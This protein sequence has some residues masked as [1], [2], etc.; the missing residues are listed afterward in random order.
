MA[1]VRHFSVGTIKAFTAFSIHW[2]AKLRRKMTWLSQH[3]NHADAIKMIS[4]GTFMYD[5][6]VTIQ[7]INLLSKDF[8]PC[9]NFMR[10]NILP[11]LS[12]RLRCDDGAVDVGET[13]YFLHHD[14]GQFSALFHRSLHMMVRCDKIQNPKIS[15]VNV[16][17]SSHPSNVESFK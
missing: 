2:L 11:A 6:M 7:W 3:Q 5:L 1:N 12:V 14:V 9:I 8:W 10:E 13:V 16:L 4:H 15:S 17:I